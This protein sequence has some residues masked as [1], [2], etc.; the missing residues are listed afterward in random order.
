MK[1]KL[2]TGAATAEFYVKK[3]KEILTSIYLYVLPPHLFTKGI[4]KTQK[5]FGEMTVVGDYDTKGNLIGIE[6]Y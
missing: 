3:N 6:V 5:T 1:K 4:R 2:M